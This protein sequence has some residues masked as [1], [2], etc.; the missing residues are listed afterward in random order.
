MHD[1]GSVR[2]RAA[3]RL[4]LEG[5]IFAAVEDWRRSQAEIPSRSKAV[6]LLL[7]L[8]LAPSGRPASA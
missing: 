2:P 5:P 6:R 7:D 1:N 4:E 8:R 3:V